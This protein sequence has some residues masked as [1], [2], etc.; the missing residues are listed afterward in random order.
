KMEILNLFT[1]N[2]LTKKKIKGSK[3]VDFIVIMRTEKVLAKLL[4]TKGEKKKKKK[5]SIIKIR[6]TT[7][8]ISNCLFSP[9]S[10]NPRRFS[11]WCVLAKLSGKPRN[12]SQPRPL[13]RI[14]KII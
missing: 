5:I 6:C 14:R 8:A 4:N 7:M 13:W 10:E 3:T 2:I 11:V 9:T 1:V 12:Y